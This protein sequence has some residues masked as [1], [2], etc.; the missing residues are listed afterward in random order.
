LGGTYSV[1]SGEGRYAATIQ[2]PIPI[3]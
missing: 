2:L 3:M 1:T